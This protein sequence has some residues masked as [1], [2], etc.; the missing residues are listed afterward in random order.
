MLSGILTVAAFVAFVGIVFW[1][2]DR[3]NADRFEAAARLPLQ[4]DESTRG[5][6]S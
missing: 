6:R 5:G 4:E 1:A 2:Y 3:R